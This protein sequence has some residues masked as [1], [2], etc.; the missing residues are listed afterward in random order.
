MKFTHIFGK[1][2]YT[3]SKTFEIYILLHFIF[4]KKGTK[5]INA[6]FYAVLLLA[7]KVTIYAFLVCKLFGPKIRL[8]KIFDKFQVWLRNNQRVT[9]VERP[10]WGKYVPPISSHLEPIKFNSEQQRRQV[11]RRLCRE[12]WIAHRSTQLHY[13]ELDSWSMQRSQ[14]KWERPSNWT[15]TTTKVHRC[16]SAQGSRHTSRTPSIRSQRQATNLLS[17]HLTFHGG[18]RCLKK[19]VVYFWAWGIHAKNVWCYGEGYFGQKKIAEKVRK[20][21]QNVNRDKS[22]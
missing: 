6:D 13:G 17:M 22:A 3:F 15:W 10:Q 9:D 4:N 21:R 12:R 8:C 16:H 11:C 5:I 20:S 19:Y 14:H 1:F 7:K 2:T 18:G